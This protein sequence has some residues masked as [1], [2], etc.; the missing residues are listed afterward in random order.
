VP[1]VS[2]PTSG[3]GGGL[4]LGPPLPLRRRLMLAPLPPDPRLG[5]ERP[6][7]LSG[8]RLEADRRHHSQ[9]IPAAESRTHRWA[10]CLAEEVCPS[11]R[12][13]KKPWRSDN[14]LRP[15][16]MIIRLMEKGGYTYLGP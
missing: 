1:P 12:R 5:H 10:W 7:A 4:E 13:G 15:V 6:L 2:T 9:Q 3:V 11:K 14:G 16:G 8:H